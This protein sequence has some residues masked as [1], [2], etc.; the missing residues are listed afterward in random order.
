VTPPRLSVAAVLELFH[1]L[2][3]ATAKFLDPMVCLTIQL[4]IALPLAG[5][6]SELNSPYR[7]PQ[8][9]FLKR[10]LADAVD[11]FFAAVEAAALLHTTRSHIRK[12]DVF[13]TMSDSCTHAEEIVYLYSIDFDRL[14]NRHLLMLRDIK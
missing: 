9:K 7:L 4:E 11:Y 1:L 2:P 3:P 6:C 5:V 8:T 12:D 14:E 13:T 10:Y